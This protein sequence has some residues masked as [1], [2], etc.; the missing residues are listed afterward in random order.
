L[1]DMIFGR[2]Q[3]PQP[4]D[5]GAPEA[6]AKGKQVVLA[7][8]IDEL[9]FGWYQMQVWILTSGFI[10]AEGAEV[11]MASGLVSAMQ[12]EFNVVSHLGKAM[13]MTWTFIGF[14]LGTLASGPLGDT[15]GRRN[16]MIFGYIGVVLTACAT[17]LVVDLNT[18]YGMRLV[19]GFFAGI[20]IP[21]AWIAI[22]EVTPAALRGRVSAV[23]GVSYILGELWAAFGLLML[24]PDLV[25]GS[26]RLLIGWAML[27]A[28][29]LVLFGMASPVTRHDTPFF[30]A[31][32]GKTSELRQLLNLMAEMNGKPDLK[33]ADEDVVISQVP[34]QIPF[35]A[36]LPTLLRPP[37]LSNV[38]II[39]FMM[40]CKDFAFYGT[41]VFWPQIWAH[42]PGMTHMNPA[43]HLMAT[44][45][46]GI[47]GICLA[48]ILM[49]T[50]SRRT[51]VLCCAAVCSVCVLFLRGLE[52]GRATAFL[53]VVGFK[54]LFPTWQMTTMLLP[55]ELFGTQIRG[56]GFSCAACV[57]RLATIV[58]PFA[59]EL[60]LDSFTGVLASLAMGAAMMVLLLPETKDCDLC[61]NVINSAPSRRNL[62]GDGSATYGAA[63]TSKV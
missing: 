26:W 48:A 51:G 27:P 30:L 62:L 46:L 56:W 63:G 57:G 37:F 25:H 60:G 12:E 18:L 16:P 29:C 42:V 28:L 23:F 43:E 15:L 52:N 20:G 6:Q 5:E 39:S 14:A 9:G 32:R 45:L 7:D 61:E 49:N 55:S 13:L 47:P 34:E 10:F 31:C 54:L 44:A 53:G 58:S 35:L 8:R 17:T 1:S 11:Q 21:T 38:L 40:F 2:N 22:S 4:K 36:V 33:L 24:M 59:V 50:L 3:A 19:L 41:D